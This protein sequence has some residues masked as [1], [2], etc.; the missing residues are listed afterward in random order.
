MIK[1]QTKTKAQSK[2][3]VERDHWKEIATVAKAE[4]EELRVMLKNVAKQLDKANRRNTDMAIRFA[5]WVDL[6]RRLGLRL[7]QWCSYDEVV[8]AKADH[9]L[10]IELSRLNE[11]FEAGS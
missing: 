5:R 1:K 7:R 9:E 2:A 10:L 6:S 4:K 11:D 8:V 3:A